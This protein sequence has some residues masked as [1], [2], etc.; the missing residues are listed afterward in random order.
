MYSDPFG[1]K[2]GSQSPRCM[3][4]SDRAGIMT[5]ADQ[6]PFSRGPDVFDPLVLSVDL[7]LSIDAISGAPE[8]KLPERNQVALSKKIFNRR[9][10][11]FRH[12]DLALIH[13]L[14]QVVGRQIYKLDLI[15]PVEQEIRYSLPYVDARDLGDNVV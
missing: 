15:G 6:Y 14:Q 9:R 11:L 13:A 12:I 3:D 2:S 1:A 5:N 7:H 10:G 4:Q 8:R